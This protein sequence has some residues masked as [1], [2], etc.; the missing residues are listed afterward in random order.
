MKKDIEILDDIKLMVDSFYGKIR[1][2]DLLG[3]IF[4]KIIEDRWPQHLEKMYRF[5][6]TVLLAEHTYIGSPFCASCKIACITST[7]QTM[8]KAF[9]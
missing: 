5:W 9:Q 4:N 8:V 7:F 1:E 6:Q 3:D 2:D